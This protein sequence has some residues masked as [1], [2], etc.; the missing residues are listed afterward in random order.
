MEVPYSAVR[1]ILCGLIVNTIIYR[2][3]RYA[4]VT[5]HLW[6][7]ICRNAKISG[8][9]DLHEEQ[10]ATLM[11]KRA[12]QPSVL[13]ESDVAFSDFDVSIRID[14]FVATPSGG[15]RNRRDDQGRPE[16]A[17]RGRHFLEE[18]QPED[19]RCG[20]VNRSQQT[21]HTGLRVFESF[22]YTR[23]AY[24]PCDTAHDGYPQSGTRC[25]ASGCATAYQS[26]NSYSDTVG[27]DVRHEVYLRR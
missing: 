12:K 5:G 23:L 24:E 1:G 22:R 2:F 20:N 13:Y 18:Q 3:D 15:E 11:Y 26:N 7:S 21:A 14:K 10:C 17:F 4:K 8:S 19:V 16:H 25:R 6:V 9:Q 27:Q